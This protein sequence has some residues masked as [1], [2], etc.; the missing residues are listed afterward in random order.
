VKRGRRRAIKP[1]IDRELGPQRRRQ[2]RA[3]EAGRGF[4][5]VASKVRGLAQRSAQAAAA[6]WKEFWPPLSRRSPPR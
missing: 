6:S 3:G 4:A 5:V 2:G 1:I